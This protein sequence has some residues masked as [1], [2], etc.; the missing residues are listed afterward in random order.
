[1]SSS[2]GALRTN[3]YLGITS[4]IATYSLLGSLALSGPSSEVLLVVLP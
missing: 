1:M 4:S 2:K 3:E